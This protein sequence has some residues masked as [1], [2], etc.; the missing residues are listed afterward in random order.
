[1]CT[2]QQ[3][4]CIFIRVFFS[5]IFAL[6]SSES[7]AGDCRQL[8]SGNHGPAACNWTVMCQA[9]ICS[10][11]LDDSAALNSMGAFVSSS[12]VARYSGCD[13]FELS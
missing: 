9:A 12:D 8:V 3:P 4:V 11:R 5:F 13:P 10:V 2:G 6:T 1:M 7:V